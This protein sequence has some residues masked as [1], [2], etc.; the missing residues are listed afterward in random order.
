MDCGLD[1]KTFH[2]PSLCKPQFAADCDLSTIVQRFLK[3]GQLP[4][5]GS[6][7]PIEGDFTGVGDFQSIQDSTAR[8]TQDF[9]QLPSEER[10]KYNNDPAVWLES[11]N[12]N[13]HNE[14]TATASD[15]AVSDDNTLS[16]DSVSSQT[17]EGVS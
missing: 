10:E 3:T 15:T 6:R 4:N 12:V 13:S 14:V 8:L 17:S 5:V 11:I 7:R 1:G 2:K 9:E 16:D